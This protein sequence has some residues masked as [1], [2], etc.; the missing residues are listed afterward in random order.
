MT[1]SV[2]TEEQRANPLINPPK[3]KFNMPAWDKIQPEH[4]E[5]AAKWAV[6]KY[7]EQIEEIK[8]VPVKKANF[9]NVIEAYEAAGK[10]ISRIFSILGYFKSNA[11]TDE[12]ENIYVKLANE[13]SP[14]FTEISS[15]EELYKRIKKV[16]SNQ[17]GFD[18]I[19]SRLTDKMFKGFEEGPLSLSEEQRREYIEL[20]QK[21]TEKTTQFSKNIMTHMNPKDKEGLKVVIK[22]EEI[23]TRLPGV[24]KNLIK[25]F[26]DKETGDVIIG[27]IPESLDIV[28]QCS[29]RETRREISYN[30]GSRGNAGKLNNDK[31]ASEIHQI[32]QRMAQLFGYKDVAEQ[33]IR[34]DTRA[35]GT[36]GNVLNILHRMRDI[37]YRASIDI[38]NKILE[39]SKADGITSLDKNADESVRLMPWDV[40]Y[41]SS[42]MKEREGGLDPEEEKKYFDVP[43]VVKGL[44]EIVKRRYGVTLEETNDFPMPSEDMQVFYSKTKSGKVNGIFIYDLYQRNNKRSGAW[45]DQWRTAGM[46]DGE[47][48][49]PIILVNCNYAVDKDAQFITHNSAKTL[50]HEKGHAL[51]GFFC[52]KTPYQALNDMVKSWD[53]IE[54]ASQFNEIFVDRGRLVNQFARHAKTD[55]PMP[56]DQFDKL[57]A[58]KPSL[59]L[60]RQN[61]LGM[62]DM[63]LYLT[64]DKISSMTD[65]NKAAFERTSILHDPNN[66]NAMINAFSHII[67]GG[68][69]AGYYSYLYADFMVSAMEDL[70]DK[71]GQ[72]AMTAFK[73]E[74]LSVGCLKDAGEAFDNIYRAL[75]EPVKPLSPDSYLRKN[76]Y[77]KY[78][79]AADAEGTSGPNV[80]FSFDFKLPKVA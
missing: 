11:K 6:E 21:L 18:A 63:E 71:H 14:V 39:E 52:Q 55:K 4:F 43:K 7:L 53:S 65:F 58:K 74:F 64:T 19:Q 9:K 41:Y 47:W 75:G 60:L 50:F 42:K 80:P 76:G 69:S 15:D 13:L 61:Q 78:L 34:P 48:Q 17:K 24:N 30:W 46:V 66:D 3:T 57:T 12:I 36:S 67:S 31:I 25:F 27:A 72:K 33:T 79:D 77:G 8:A 54:L 37:G 32:K 59:Q 44:H 40:A 73:R 5:P 35:A 70:Y 62:L 22:K 49:V 16:H 1:K 23:A 28:E 20:Q 51:E 38:Y 26:T 29:N 68:Y 2:L 56:K 10:D 45:M